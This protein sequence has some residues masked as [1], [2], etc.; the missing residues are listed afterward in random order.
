MRWLP[1]LMTLGLACAEARG[2][3]PIAWEVIGSEEFQAAIDRVV[4]IDV[5]DCGFLEITEKPT[6]DQ[7]RAV[8]KCIED[9]KRRGVESIFATS[10]VSGSKY[11]QDVFAISASGE[12]WLLTYDNDPMADIEHILLRR[13]AAV[14]VDWKTLRIAGVDCAESELPK[15]GGK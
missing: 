8:R 4:S 3:T 6:A 11:I 13:C 12:R 15:P 9:A 7:I 14:S 1:A 5:V 10:H 2:A